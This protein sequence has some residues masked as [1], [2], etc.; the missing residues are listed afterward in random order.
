MGF[1]WQDGSAQQPHNGSTRDASVGLNP[2]LKEF[3]TREIADDL[4]SVSSSASTSTSSDFARQV[5]QARQDPSNPQAAAY[6]DSLDQSKI[7]ASDRK[8]KQHDGALR[9]CSILQ[10][11]LQDCLQHGSFWERST[12]CEVKRKAFWDCFHQQRQILSGFNYG[13][14]EH[15]PQL[16]GVLLDRADD[17]SQEQRV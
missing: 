9:N 2:D 16:D 15:S 11:E 7:T 14:A 13:A 4:S 3:Y 12:M 17:L 8:G 6:L 10:I 5:H 1:F